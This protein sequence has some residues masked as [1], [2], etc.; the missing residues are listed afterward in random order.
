M[1]ADSSWPR[2]F[3]EKTLGPEWRKLPP[4]RTYKQGMT[5]PLKPS[6][7]QAGAAAVERFSTL[8]EIGQG[9]MGIIYRARQNCLDREV[10]LKQVRADVSENER[11]HHLLGQEFIT[12]ALVNGCLQHPNIVPVYD[13]G[14]TARGELYM[15]M[16]LVGGQSWEELLVEDSHDLDFHVETLVQVCNAVA[17]AHSLGLVH[18]DL[19]PSNVM[20]GAFGE[21]LVMDWGL[22]V[23]ICHDPA[24]ARIRHKTCICEFCG[25]PAY[26]PPELARGLGM[27][28]GVWTD[29]YLLGGILFRIVTGT[30]P[31]G[32]QDLEEVIE[33]A[34]QGKILPLSRQLPSE[35][36]SIILRALAAAPE[37]RHASV[38]E[39]QDELRSF[40]KH[41]ESVIISEAAQ[42]KLEGCQF[43]SRRIAG[44][45]EPERNRLYE[46]FAQAVAGFNQA[47]RLWAHNPR[48]LE[49]ERRARLEYAEAALQQGDLGLAEAQGSKLE[50]LELGQDSGTYALKAAGT[51]VSDPKLKVRHAAPLRA[52]IRAAR[53]LQE[54][55]R[56]ARRRLRVQLGATLG[57]V[58]FGLVLG[59][60]V[61]QSKN[62][63]IADKATA[64]DE[65]RA[66]AEQRGEIAQDALDELAFKVN[67]RLLDELGSQRA[68]E[69]AREILYAALEGWRKLQETNSA[70]GVLSRNTARARIRLGELKRDLDG[71]L[72]GALE[73]FRTALEILDALRAEGTDPLAEQGFADCLVQL[74]NVHRLRGELELAAEQYERSH[75]LFEQLRAAGNSSSSQR[76]ES[77]RAMEGMAEIA[78]ARGEI[79]AAEEYFRASLALKSAVLEPGDPVRLREF[80]SSLK[81]HGEVLE[82]SGQL[83]KARDAYGEALELDRAL[84]QADSSSVRA[85]ADLSVALERFGTAELKQGSSLQAHSAFSEALALARRLVARDPVSAQAR[86][87]LSTCLRHYGETLRAQ[88]SLSEARDALYEALDLMRELV[89]LDSS[90]AQSKSELAELLGE[91]GE[92]LV[93]VGEPLRARAL[94]IESLQLHRELLRL[95]P[96]NSEVRGDLVRSLKKVGDILS[97]QGDRL[98]AR[99]HFEEGLEI[100]RALLAKDP[101][102]IFLQRNLVLMLEK[103]GDF[104]L[105][106]GDLEAAGRSHREGL[107]L[108]RA[109]VAADPTNAVS[110]RNLFVALL[111]LGRVLSAEGA[112]LRAREVYK[113]GLD[114][115][116]LL[117]FKDPADV[118]LRRD[119][120]VG[121]VHYGGILEQLG[122]RDEARRIFAEQADNARALLQLDPSSLQARRDLSATLGRLG[123]LELDAGKGD[124]AAALLAESVALARE[125]EPAHP[126]DQRALA[127]QLYNLSLAE[128]L[129]GRLEAAEG[130]VE[131]ALEV[132]RD[133]A[134]TAPW[135]AQDI[136]SFV[137]LHHRLLL[138]QFLAGDRQPSSPTD[139]A[140]LGFDALHKGEH[141]E[142]LGWYE[143]AFA[144]GVPD[145]LRDHLLFAAQAGAHLSG[146]PEPEGPRYALLALGWL[147]RWLVNLQASVTA[148]LSAPPDEARDFRL[149]A[150]RSTW[151]YVRDEDPAFVELR[152]ELSFQRLFVD[153]VE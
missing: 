91:L 77:S 69:V 148:L 121:L 96:Q 12:E 125:L 30:P 119:L 111:K 84:Y 94:F 106:E 89:R 53:R 131:A 139:F 43:E 102:S 82:Q 47:R 133:L 151:R 1:E 42:E 22:A 115:L 21:V 135:L 10:A 93:L 49:G 132:L 61:L 118:R 146:Q 44:L 41:R 28:V 113:E 130:H 18:N 24:G 16:K 127:T 112:P 98:A 110:R 60:M 120:N 74:G 72:E 7:V 122:E 46:K 92:I 87:R 76:W 116:R 141:L 20:I 27:R 137:F 15:A 19:K 6:E 29:V 25:T 86:E 107:E 109:I 75:Q 95:D 57:L 79:E 4:G 36:R 123:A 114:I 64:L 147:E 62:L 149:E 8:S 153:G 3:W 65:Q 145:A 136:D 140:I 142:A 23:E 50:A 34:A 48:A 26:A 143:Q 83:Q 138:R 85:C 5:Q 9:G 100:Q 101:D 134:E 56:R 59:I 88:G 66:F 73:E 71:D 51:R 33:A 35:L 144:G 108:Q 81:K 14:N 17:Y 90:H 78:R 124:A 38:W 126:I 11:D 129:R 150:L 54:S 32:G 63:E 68:N 104:A 2:L 58:F 128:N 103:L 39:L 13:L 152:R 105:S 80:S 117:A 52:K 99:Q 97:E 37:E 55:E 70:Q 40:L 45:S 67:E 31:H